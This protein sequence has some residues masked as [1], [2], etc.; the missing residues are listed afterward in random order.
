MNAHPHT[1][2]TGKVAVIHNGIIENYL[3]LKHELKDR[4]HKFKSE[5]DTESVAFLLADELKKTGNLA[6]AMRAI[7]KRLKGSFTLLAVDSDNPS[8]IVGA[9]RNSPLV[10][11]VGKGEN[12]LASDVSAFIAFTKSALELGQDQVVEV[13]PEKSRGNGSR[14]SNRYTACI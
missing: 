1:D 10:V 5:T 4:G 2:E 9:R 6:S 11:G 8:I 3:E 12:Y 14:R 7:C 13:S